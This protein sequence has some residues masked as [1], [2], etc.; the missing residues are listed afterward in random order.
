MRGS[1]KIPSLKALAVAAGGVAICLASVP[2]AAQA[3]IE[4]VN[5]W[6]F[7]FVPY[8]WLAGV[9]TDV[10]L[11]PLPG[12]T[13]NVSAGSIL[14]A[15]NLA[16][17]GTLEARRGDWGGLLDMQYIRIGVSDDV[18]GGLLGGYNVRLTEQF[19]TGL[20]SYRLVN[21]P[22]VAVDLLGGAR[23]ANAK[24]TLNVFPSPL[25]SGLYTE[26]SKGWWNGVLGVRAQVPVADKWSLLGYLDGGDGGGSTSWQ[27]IAGASYQYSPS[28]SLKFGYRY[29]SF[30]RKDDQDGL[31]RK[32]ALGG[33]YLGAGFKF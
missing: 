5:D 20:V 7:E 14:G 31:I 17:M 27:A 6:R 3:A 19:Y 12:N 22:S 30:D 33:I 15:V 29:L 25:G 13:L 16:G 28:T 1:R 21:S 26:G 11:G 32:M 24:T 4:S 18:A 23:Y 9:R 8:L 2:A 10:K